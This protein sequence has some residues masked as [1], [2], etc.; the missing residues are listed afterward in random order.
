MIV[1]SH[2][3]GKKN[4]VI[5]VLKSVIYASNISC[6]ELA[7]SIK[8][9]SLVAARKGARFCLG[10]SFLSFSLMSEKHLEQH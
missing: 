9:S 3:N 2:I 5:I 8:G 7:L 1:R 10:V 6:R 4:S